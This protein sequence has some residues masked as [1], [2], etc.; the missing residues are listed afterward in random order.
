MR[1]L[2]QLESGSTA[3]SGSGDEDQG[4]DTQVEE[5]IEEVP[6]D[7]ADGDVAKRIRLTVERL[8]RRAE[9]A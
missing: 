8:K 6:R 3:R 5:D 4:I 7:K 1:G 9:N 2:L